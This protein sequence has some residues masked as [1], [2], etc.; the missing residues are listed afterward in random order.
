MFASSR[1]LQ[2]LGQEKLQKNIKSKNIKKIKTKSKIKIINPKNP[3]KIIKLT[4]ITIFMLSSKRSS[5]SINDTMTSQ[6]KKYLQNHMEK[7]ES[8][9]TIRS[10][11]ILISFKS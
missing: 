4:Q 11:I 1:C 8:N 9:L 10:P 3:R 6:R 2:D 7:F 5:N